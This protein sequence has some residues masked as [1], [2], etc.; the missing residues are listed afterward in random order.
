MRDLAKEVAV[1][2][3]TKEVDDVIEKRDL[4]RAE[5][6]RKQALIQTLTQKCVVLQAEI[7]VLEARATEMS[8]DGAELRATR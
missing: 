7:D 2:A 4:L 1:R 8:E 5:L 6:V 3:L